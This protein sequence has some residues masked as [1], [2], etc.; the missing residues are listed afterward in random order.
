M[1]IIKTNAI[2]IAISIGVNRF[3]IKLKIRLLV[4]DGCV[5]LVI[6]LSS[7]VFT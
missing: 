5:S 2:N 7:A 1:A 6:L 4:V 3:L